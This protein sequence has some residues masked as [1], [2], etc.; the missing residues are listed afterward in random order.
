MENAAVEHLGDDRLN[1]LWYGEEGGGV[2]DATTAAVVDGI[3]R[4]FPGT[5]GMPYD[6]L[7]RRERVG[8]GPSPLSPA[9]C[10]VRLV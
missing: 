5:H 7:E 10:K 6:F 3:C 1:M 9:P 2:G 8:V 4:D